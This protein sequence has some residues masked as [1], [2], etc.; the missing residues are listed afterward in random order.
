MA[1]SVV[2][3]VESSVDMY[4]SKISTEMA[5]VDACARLVDAECIFLP[6]CATRTKTLT[7]S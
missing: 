3:N 6:I 4:I 7:N 5:N 2:Q 1:M